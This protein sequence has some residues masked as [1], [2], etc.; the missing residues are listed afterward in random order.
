MTRIPA[1]AFFLLLLPLAVSAQDR[2]ENVTVTGQTSRARTQMLRD[3]IR[4]TVALSYVDRKLTRWYTP[5]CPLVIGLKP[6]ENAAVALR[7]R[8]DAQSVGAQVA[9]NE[10]CAANV[11]ITFAPDPQALMTKI[12][13][14]AN[15]KGNL[16]DNDGAVHRQKLSQIAAPIQA[17]YATRTTQK[18]GVLPARELPY[19]DVTNY[20]QATP[21]YLSQ[22]SRLGDGIPSNLV[23]VF[24]V[25]DLGKVDGRQVGAIAD[26]VAILTL[27]K[28]PAFAACRPLPSVTNLLSPDCDESLKTAAL[29][30]ADLAFLRGVYKADA[31][32]NMNLA[33]GDILREMEK[34]PAGRDIKIPASVQAGSTPSTSAAK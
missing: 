19:P 6:E 31:G 27:L 12:A 16:G 26:Y 7:I 18:Y 34:S 9:E 2:T 20:C 14:S 17:W 1:V 22:A 24:V 25:V 30:D 10:P 33:R 29:S 4:S 23:N 21:C 8:N 32:Q 28:T 13:A 11:T 15:R 3:F 5:I